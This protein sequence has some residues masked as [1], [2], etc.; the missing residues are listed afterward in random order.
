MWAYRAA[1][2]DTVTIFKLEL[3]CLENC[4]YKAFFHL[5]LMKQGLLYLNNSWVSN[6]M[7]V[8]M[9]WQWTDTSPLCYCG[10]RRNLWPLTSLLRLCTFGCLSGSVWSLITNTHLGHD[11]L[12][13]MATHEPRGQPCLPHTESTCWPHI[14]LFMWIYTCRCVSMIHSVNSLCLNKLV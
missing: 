14:G 1:T 10:N 8:L 2:V 4:V 13:W 5:C 11:G 6:A 9:R 12:W 7:S 3:I